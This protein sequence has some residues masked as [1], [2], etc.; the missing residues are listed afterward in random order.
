MPKMQSRRGFISA[1]AVAGAG[2][3]LRAPRVLAAEGALETTTVRLSYDLSICSPILVAEELLRAEGFTDVRYVEAPATRRPGARERR[4]RFPSGDPVA[5]RAQ[6]RISSRRKNAASSDE[7]IADLLNTAASH[8]QAPPFAHAYCAAIR[9]TVDLCRAPD[10]SALLTRPMAPSDVDL[11]HSVP[12][13]LSFAEN[14]AA[15]PLQVDPRDRK[16]I[17]LGVATKTKGDRIA[18]GD[19]GR[20]ADVLIGLAGGGD[21]PTTAFGQHPGGAWC[22][23]LDVASPGFAKTE[24]N[25]QNGRHSH[26]VEDQPSLI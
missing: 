7:T 19:P 1:V 24:G 6:D 9:P 2:R 18:D 15:L 23:G 4:H 25:E 22:D 12:I 17:I 16:R 10:A 11:V 3:L 21:N 5:P 14:R 20:Q 13:T 26:P 8:R